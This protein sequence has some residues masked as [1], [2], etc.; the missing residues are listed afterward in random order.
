MKYKSNTNPLNRTAVLSA[1]ALGAAALFGVS[2]M[3]AGAAAP[4]TEKYVNLQATTP[5]TPQTGNANI[6]GTMIAGQFS[7]T[8]GALTGLDASNIGAGILANARTTG[9]SANTAN[10]LVLRNASGGF[11]AGTILGNFNGAHSGFGALLTGLNAANISSGTLDDI[12]LSANIP[13]LAA[14]QSFT[15]INTFDQGNFFG[16][17]AKFAAIESRPDD[18]ALD[19]T[20]HVQIHGNPDEAALSVTGHAVIDGNLNVKSITLDS[21]QRSLVFPGIAFVG[22]SVKDVGYTSDGEVTN[23]ASIGRQRYFAPVQLPDG[24]T[25]TSMRATI[26]DSGTTGDVQLLLLRRPIDPNGPAGGTMAQIDASGPTTGFDLFIDSGISAPVVDVL[27]YM[28][29]LR[30]EMPHGGFGAA[31]LRSVRIT[32]TITALP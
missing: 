2:V 16:I 1:F 12:H 7:G 27:N 32:Y 8:G 21:T 30:V 26:F 6:S 15:G 11:S 29:F 23:L 3:N 28:Y 20:G 13:R 22:E 4:P 14:D 10:T 17:F 25:V 5:G 24:A 9:D 31:A 19:V 18:L